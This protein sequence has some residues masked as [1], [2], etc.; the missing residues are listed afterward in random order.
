MVPEYPV[1]HDPITGQPYYSYKEIVRRNYCKD[2]NGLNP[3]HLE[4]YLADE[5]FYIYFNM[6]KVSYTVPAFRFALRIY[7]LM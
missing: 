5:D 1:G 4:L 2:F 7:L 3:Q 6:T